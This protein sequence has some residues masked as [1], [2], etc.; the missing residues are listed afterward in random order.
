MTLHTEEQA[1]ARWCPFVRAY[2]DE[3]EVAVASYNRMA[4]MGE[5][6][7]NA[8]NIEA[9]AGCLCIASNCMAWRWDESKMDAEGPL[10]GYCGLAGRVE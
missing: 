2:F 5:G 1:R 6:E 8:E 7:P 4:W 3:R 9:N 10:L